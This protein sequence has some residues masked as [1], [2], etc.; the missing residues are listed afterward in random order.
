[1]INHPSSAGGLGQEE[2]GVRLWGGRTVEAMGG[3]GEGLTR[4]HGA[5][6]GALGGGRGLVGVA[7]AS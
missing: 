5:G 4:G 1:M 6:G 2:L 3:G 7:L